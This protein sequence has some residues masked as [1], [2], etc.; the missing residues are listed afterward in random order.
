VVRS[1]TRMAS[2][3]MVVGPSSRV[4]AELWDSTTPAANNRGRHRRAVA[5]QAA[6]QGKASQ[7]SGKQQHGDGEMQKGR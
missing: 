3:M 2:T 1:G 6:R 5:Q 4:D 7:G